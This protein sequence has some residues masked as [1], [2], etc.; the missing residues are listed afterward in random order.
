[1]ADVMTASPKESYL[2][3][4]QHLES[5]DSPAWLKAVREQGLAQFQELEFPHARMEDW[6]FTNVTP[7]L[8]AGYA[9]RTAAPA[10]E[11]TVTDI[12]PFLFHEPD[13]SELVFVDGYLAPG[14]S[15]IAK[16]HASLTVNGL[17]A[18]ADRNGNALQDHLDRHVDKGDAF[19]ALN[20]AFLQDGA[21]V[22]VPDN[23]AVDGVIHLVF[24]TTDGSQGMTAY[25]RNLMVIGRNSQARIVESHVALNG[26]GHYLNDAVGEIVLRD[27]ARLS[28]HKIISESNEG[29]HLAV[30]N[31]RQ[32]AHSFFTSFVF[33][34]HGAIVRNK[35]RVL[36]AGQGAECSLHGLYLN[37]GDRLI[38]NFITIDHAVPHCRSRIAYKGV[39]DH[40]SRA[41]FTGKVDV[42]RGAQK[43]DSN[44]LNQNFLLADGAT[45]DTKPQLEIY[46]D[47]VKCTHGATIGSPP[48]PV[49]FYFR[50]RGMDEAMARGI[51]TYGFASEVVYDL[52]IDPLKARLNADIFDRYS[53]KGR[54]QGV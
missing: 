10:H 29:H 33:T 7:L 41:V 49:V 11:L 25:P 20:S 6:R 24:I 43:T 23:A 48:E 30:T 40:A 14:L 22:A 46:A 35:L 38:D 8:N 4:W 50:S 32:E 16:D 2:A 26:A 31:V 44:Q 27:N 1:M 12:A 53:P 36:L 28:H 19:T 47:D 45:I 52:E 21:Y 42:R 3:G 17:H 9:S 34:F 54:P 37:D 18:A 51:L 5:Q 39:L 13:W 15:R